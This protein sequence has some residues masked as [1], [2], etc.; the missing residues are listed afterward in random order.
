[1]LGPVIPMLRIFDVTK[2]REFYLDFLGFTVDFE[3]R[4]GENFP[5]YM[6]ISNSGCALHLTEHYGDALPGAHL[7]IR[8]DDIDALA[9]FLARQDYRYAKPGAPEQTPWGTKELTVTDPFGNRLTFFQPK[10]P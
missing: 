8:S 6:G 5:L 9:Q 4:F 3:H 7:R 2:A 10:G 1:M